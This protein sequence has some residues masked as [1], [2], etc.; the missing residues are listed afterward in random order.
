MKTN[1]WYKDVYR[2][3]LVDM[4]INDTN[5][6]YLSKF[7]PKEYFDNLK[8]AHI[9]A[10]MIYLQAHTGLCYYP[11]KV[12]RTH[13]A[14][15]GENNGIKQLVNMCKDDGLK[16]VGYYSLIFNNVAADSHPEWEMVNADGTTWRDHGQRYGLCC[17]NNLE[18]RKFLDKNIKELSEYFTNL[19]AMF[20]DMPYWEVTCHCLACQKRYLK[21]T[22][23]KLPVKED[24]NDPNWLL[25]VKKRQDWMVEFAHFAKDTSLKYMPNYT[26]ELNF[27]AVIGCNWLGGS[28]E[29]INDACEFTGGDLYGDL[30]SH[31][32]TAKYY[33]GVTKNQ[34][35]EYM[36][37]RCNHNLREHT[38]TKPQEMLDSEILLT[39]AH[40]G[41]TLNI[42]AINPDGTLDSRI[43]KKIGKAFE[44]QMP[45]EQYM[46]KGKLYAD[47]AVYFDSKTLFEEKYAKTYNKLCA[48]NAHKT[49]VENHVPTAVIANTSL[50]DLS[51]YKMIIAPCLQD[52]DNDEPLK[53]VEYVKNGGILYLSGKSDSRLMKEFFNAEFDKYTFED[54]P[55]E[56][57]YK[58]YAEV[59]AYIYPENDYEDIF[60]EFNKKYPMPIVYKLPTFKSMNGEVKARLTLPYTD[61]D[62]NSVYASIHSNPPGV[63]KETPMMAEVNYGLGKVIWTSALIENDDRQNYK[64]IF[65]KIV[66]R[67]VSPK[68]EVKTNK[69]VESVI[70]EDNEKVYLSLVD[71]ND[72]FEK[73]ERK[74]ELKLPFVASKIHNITTGEDTLNSNYLSGRFTEF[75]MFEIT[76]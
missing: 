22:G 36:T 3:Q 43:Y 76:K 72:Y 63:T 12:A 26:V 6:E 5:D 59:Q 54:S 52:F 75:V 24:W 51:Q 60:G 25:Y 56:R 9:E 66:K 27:A 13:K 1:K 50:K 35:F 11:T 8:T 18:Y 10:P 30:Y 47:V 31:S 16:V 38:V 65:M 49:L 67:F 21:E 28:T 61:P 14:M 37:C 17:P 40:H 15:L 45:Y 39:C 7:N 53:F 34:P 20:Y 73:D 68:Y 46:N 70:F 33:Y 48:V 29:G 64:D 58:G 4:H 71:I 57:V 32:F 62:N 44:K 2:R 74:F 23:N 69:Y 19:D 42:D 41:A 55:F